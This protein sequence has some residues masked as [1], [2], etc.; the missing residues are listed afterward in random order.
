MSLLDW[1]EM[2][3]KLKNLDLPTRDKL[4]EIMLAENADKYPDEYKAQLWAKIIENGGYE[5]LLS[6]F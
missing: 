5:C 1:L 2:Q 4:S 3:A 6:E